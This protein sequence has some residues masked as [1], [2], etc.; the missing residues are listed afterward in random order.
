MKNVLSKTNGCTF[1]IN[2]CPIE[3]SQQMFIRSAAMDFC[4]TLWY[5]YFS[6]CICCIPWGGKSY[7]IPET[8]YLL[9]LVQR[10]GIVEVIILSVR[11]NMITIPLECCNNK[12]NKNKKKRSIRRTFILRLISN[13]PGWK[14]NNVWI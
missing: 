2:R 1:S 5:I 9:R 13:I 11:N 12:K 3:G 4:N 7:S 6:L 14:Y 8:Y 10:F